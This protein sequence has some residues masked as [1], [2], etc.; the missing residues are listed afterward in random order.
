[1]D[2]WTNDYL[3]RY[4]VCKIALILVCFNF[5][6]QHLPNSNAIKIQTSVSL[7]KAHTFFSFSLF[8][9]ETH[10]GGE[11]GDAWWSERFR[12][13][14]QLCVAALITCP[15]TGVAAAS[16]EDSLQSFAG[17]TEVNLHQ[18]IGQL[19]SPLCVILKIMIFKWQGW[20]WWDQTN[21]EWWQT[22]ILLLLWTI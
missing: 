15:G 14:L 21:E 19:N 2:G 5:N 3:R 6:L 16:H 18:D 9:S 10:S 11:A 1:M 8:V 12:H 20:L 17:L 7:W 4:G 22:V 13:Q